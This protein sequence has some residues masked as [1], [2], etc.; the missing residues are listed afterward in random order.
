MPPTVNNMD[1]YKKFKK[2]VRDLL[3]QE[4]FVEAV[5][6][7]GS[8]DFSYF[9]ETIPGHFSLLGM[10]DETQGYASSHS[11]H[12]RINEDVLPYG[13]AIHATMAVQYLKDKASKGS[14]SGFHDEL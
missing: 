1:L 5:P 11:P 3:G 9:A 14:V 4:A 6:E 7:M 12:Y 10:Q 8:E 2:V 13:A